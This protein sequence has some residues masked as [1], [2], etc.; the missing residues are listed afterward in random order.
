MQ[1]F[2]FFR[3]FRVFRGSNAVF[4]LINGGNHA[5]GNECKT[6]QGSFRPD[7][8]LVDQRHKCRPVR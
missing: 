2:D 4:R 6:A 5:A 7:H 1:A 3:V 8:A